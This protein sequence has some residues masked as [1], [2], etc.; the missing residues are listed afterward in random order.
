MN[1]FRLSIVAAFSVF[2]AGASAIAAERPNIL[3][4]LVDDM[5]VMDTSVP[6]VVDANGKPSS[7]PLNR[8]YQTPAMQRLANNGVRFTHFYANSVCSPSRAS[9]LTGQYS[10]RHKTTQ[11]INPTGR[12]AG[13]K[14]W[15]WEGM[16]ADDVTLQ[17]TLQKAGYTTVHLGKAHLG[18]FKHVGEDPLKVGFDLNI[19]GC[20]IGRPTTYFGEKN[21]GKGTVR[22]VPHLEKYHGTKTFL[23]EALTLEAKRILTDVSKNGDPFF[24]HMSHYALHGPWDPDPRFMKNYADSGYS[25][26]AQAF[27][28]LAEGMDKSLADLVAH[29]EEIGEA[30]NTL[31]VFL[32]DNGSDAPI[33]KAKGVGSSA[34][35]RGKKGTCYE[36]GML[37][38]LI[39]SWA[40]P[41]P[42]S[43]IQKKFPIK[44]GV[45]S[46]DFVTICDLMPT[47]LKVA[48][49]E[50]PQSHKMD[51]VELTSYLASH[52]GNHKQEFLMHFPH[53]H[54][55]SQFTVFRDG[56]WKVI[57]RYNQKGDKRFELY[58][59]ADDIAEAN[60]LAKKEPVK[61]KEILAKMQQALDDSG[62]QY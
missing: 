53:Q 25:K 15:N 41:N 16:K 52:T 13:P 3:V 61:L 43:A 37:A 55:S 48:G 40:K 34:P 23:T 56:E 60:N 39:V 20:A 46:Q 54:N 7:Q 33:G 32:G 8:F 12:N 49:A 44:T 26:R 1:S 24:M 19:G 21:Y 31:I 50:V 6:F 35:Y 2:S 38:P 45:V 47:L 9:L 29:L 5:G 51:G 14:G 57:K 58:H 27:A 30:E 62:A 59:L 11:W 17:G 42:D 36:G 10:A 28:A 18:P 22:A 4:F